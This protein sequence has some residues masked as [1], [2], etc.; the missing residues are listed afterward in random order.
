MTSP[1][2]HGETPSVSVI[3][4]AY[5]SAPF[6]EATIASVYA[7]TVLPAEVIVINDGSTDDTERQLRRMAAEL[8]PSFV[9]RTKPNGGEASARNLGIRL[10]TGELVAFLDHD[11]LWHPTKLER[12]LACMAADRELAL[13]FTGYTFDFRDFRAAPGRNIAPEVIHHERWDPDPEAVLTQLLDGRCPVGTLS[14]TLFRRDALLQVTPFDER[15]GLGSDYQ[16]YL[17]FA[18]K[19]L[20]MTYLPEVLVEY[21]WHGANQSRDTGIL[22]ENLCRI[23]DRFFAEYGA[24]LP[25]RIRSRASWWRAH[26]HLQTAID[27]FQSGDRARARRHI[28]MA[29]LID[30]RSIRPGWVRMLGIGPP[31]RATAGAW[32]GR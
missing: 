32:P 2:A 24:Q 13:S 22:W 27:A 10:A 5:N 19:G 8:P 30:P 4:P 23:F 12:Q 31:P 17:H 25:E 26:W 6:I 11:D 9:W 28:V 20:K 18:A 15:V 29:A 14:T 16:M 21:R 7:Q 3:V 1:A